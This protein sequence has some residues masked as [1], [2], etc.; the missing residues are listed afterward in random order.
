[1][2]ARFYWWFFCDSFSTVLRNP[3]EY[4]TMENNVGICISTCILRLFHPCLFQL[5][6][7]KY[8]QEKCFCFPFLFSRRVKCFLWYETKCGIIA[9]NFACYD[10]TLCWTENRIMAPND[11]LGFKKPKCLR[12]CLCVPLP[13]LYYTAPGSL[14]AVL[15]CEYYTF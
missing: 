10:A 8:L 1:M 15:T 14:I 12:V 9:E 7:L 11:L 13:A 6:H 3:L 2:L 5:R 4:E